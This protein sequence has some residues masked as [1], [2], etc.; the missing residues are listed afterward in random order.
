MNEEMD[1]LHKNKTWDLAKLLIRRKNVGFK[2]VL[3]EKL[4]SID[5]VRKYKA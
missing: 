1:S 5:Q 2:W 3:K 4:H